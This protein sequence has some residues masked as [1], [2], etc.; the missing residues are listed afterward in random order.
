M[1]ITRYFMDT[2]WNFRE[3]LLVFEPLSGT[4]SSEN[5]G[6]VVFKVLQDHDIMDRVL[7]VITNNALNNSTLVKNLQQA[8]NSLEL[9]ASLIT[10]I[11]RIPYLAH[12][13]QLSLRDLLSAIKVNPINNT[14][15][16]Q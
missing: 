16:R 5:L 13:I 14:A 1:A 15:N 4:H 9:P 2:D 8:I 10:P 3:I 12:I 6:T 11:I 7:A